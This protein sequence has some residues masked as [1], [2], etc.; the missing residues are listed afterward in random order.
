MGWI[1]GYGS[2]LMVHPF[3]TAPNVVSV[4]P[5]MGVLFPVLRRGKLSSNYLLD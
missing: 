3:V 2:L 1:P 5:T 4:T